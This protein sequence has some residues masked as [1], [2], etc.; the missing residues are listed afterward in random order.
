[1][2]TIRTLGV[3]DAPLFVEM[4]RLSLS[5]DP[6][7]F[8]A[9]PDTDAAS[10]LQFVRQR[11]AEAATP[12]DGSFVLGAFEKDLVGIVGVA[13]AAASTVRVWGFFVKP[14]FRGRG[15][16]KT[17]VERATELA[18]RLPNVVRMELGVSDSSVAARRLYEQAGFVDTGERTAECARLMRSRS[19]NMRPAN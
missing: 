17:L 6:E 3:D 5:I 4:R 2:V 19:Q 18:V 8:S 7:A 11:F 1:M 9:N 10:N 16:G 13:R 12:E 15:I 14:E